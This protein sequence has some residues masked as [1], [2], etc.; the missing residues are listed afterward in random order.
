MARS[1]STIDTLT[2][3]TDIA[4]ESVYLTKS[5]Q[6]LWSLRSYRHPSHLVLLALASLALLAVLAL[7]C[8]RQGVLCQDIRETET[9][10]V[11]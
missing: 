2:S 4:H 3:I 11:T 6:L 10:C 9:G 1:Q 8:V 7:P 5:L